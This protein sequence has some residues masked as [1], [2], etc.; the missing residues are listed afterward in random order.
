MNEGF[1]IATDSRKR[2]EVLFM[3]DRRKQRISFWSNQL[4]EAFVYLDENAAHSKAAS[5]RFNNPRVIPMRSAIKILNEHERERMHEA[6]LA[7]S[8]EW[9]Y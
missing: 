3:V 5:Y 8:E 9:K 2:N 1:V 7:V 6:A 4:D